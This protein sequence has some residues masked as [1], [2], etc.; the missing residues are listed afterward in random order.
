[1]N[2]GEYESFLSFS[3]LVHHYFFDVSTFCCAQSHELHEMFSSRDQEAIELISPSHL[4]L[5]GYEKIIRESCSD[6]WMSSG[7]SILFF[8]FII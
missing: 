3:F 2:T 5:L 1:M 4:T 7:N 8:N 6:I